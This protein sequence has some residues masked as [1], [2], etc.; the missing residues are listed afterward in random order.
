VLLIQAK[1]MKVYK[2][3]SL[4]GHIRMILKRLGRL[5]RVIWLSD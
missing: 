3:S 2:T 4:V 5:F 1:L